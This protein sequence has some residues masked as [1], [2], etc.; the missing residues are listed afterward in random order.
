MD[1]PGVG[2][3]RQGLVGGVDYT[4]GHI[5]GQVTKGFEIP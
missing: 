2:R 1:V 3:S 5:E 4:S